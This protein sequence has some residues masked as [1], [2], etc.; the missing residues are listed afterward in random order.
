MISNERWIRKLTEIIFAQS[1]GWVPVMKWEQD[2]YGITTM[3]HDTKGNQLLSVSWFSNSVS[4]VPVATM[5][6][7]YMKSVQKIRELMSEC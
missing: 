4:T 7:E 1:I 6:P 3:V 5:P 2:I